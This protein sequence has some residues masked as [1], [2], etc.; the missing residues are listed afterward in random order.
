MYPKPL[1]NMGVDTSQFLMRIVYLE[2]TQDQFEHAKKL[3][4]EL[5]DGIRLPNVSMPQFTVLVPE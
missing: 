5:I 4:Q 1:V 2:G 3:I